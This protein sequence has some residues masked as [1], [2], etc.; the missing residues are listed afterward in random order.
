[1]WYSVGFSFESTKKNGTKT[2]QILKKKI[3]KKKA[4]VAKGKI[5]ML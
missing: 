1:M 5:N 2:T 3:E 4:N